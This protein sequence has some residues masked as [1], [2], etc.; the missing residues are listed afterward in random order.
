MPASWQSPKA[1]SS[2]QKEEC[3][4]QGAHAST[5]ENFH[6][7]HFLAKCRLPSQM[8]PSKPLLHAVLMQ[9]L[10][11]ARSLLLRCASLGVN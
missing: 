7:M 6:C 11:H 5:M 9:P 4:T 8:Q 10:G 2:L 3:L 1:R